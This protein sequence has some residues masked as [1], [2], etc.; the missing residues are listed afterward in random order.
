M[1]IINESC[2]K[3]SDLDYGEAFIFNDELYMRIKSNEADA[4]S[5]ETG[6][7]HCFT[8]IDDVVRADVRVVLK[9]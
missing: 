2:P 4:V 6:E 8:D 7:L 1:K 9:K 5:L 3:I